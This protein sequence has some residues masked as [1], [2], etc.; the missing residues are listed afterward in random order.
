MRQSQQPQ[1]KAVWNT[2]PQDMATI[3]YKLATVVNGCFT[4]IIRSGFGTHAFAW[5]VGS[6]ILMIFYGGAAHCP[7]MQI[8]IGVW[9]MFVIMRRLKPDKRQHSRY[10]GYPWLMHLIPFVRNEY[11]ARLI[12]P[13]VV[14]FGGVFLIGESPGMAQFFILGA[15]SLFMVLG[16]ET[17]ALS[18]TSGRWKTPG[19]KPCR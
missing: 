10:Q 11:Q 6:L 1:D 14:F 2:P 17:A 16:M 8:Y 3:F 12:E 13:W 5:Y 19:K 7:E 18:R 9:F 15:I 4:P